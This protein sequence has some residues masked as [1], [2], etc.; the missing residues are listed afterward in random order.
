MT[1]TDPSLH[2]ACFAD[3]PASGTPL[4]NS[5]AELWSLLNFL[6]PSLF[7]SS[8][9]FEEWFGCG[10]QR[11][12]P[13]RQQQTE[14]GGA[15]AAGGSA[16]QA[17]AG[18]E[19]ED[20]EDEAAAEAAEAAGLSEEET[21]IVTSRLHQVGLLGWAG[22]HRVGMGCVL[23]SMDTSMSIAGLLVPCLSWL[24]TPDPQPP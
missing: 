16:G 18:G 10:G 3:L 15:R 13:Q 5:L 1:P 12:L 24:A 19:S 9:D 11:K 7:D 21:L 22:P 23:L 2:L 17:G 4:Q 14:E 6:L 8:D 20:E